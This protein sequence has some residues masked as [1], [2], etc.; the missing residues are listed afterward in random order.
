M[1]AVGTP[2]EWLARRP[3][4]READRRLAVEVS[5]IGVETAEYYP[6]LTLLGNFGGTAQSFGGLNQSIAQRWSYGPSLTWSL[7]DFGRIKQRV[8]AQEARAAGAIAAYQE[9]W[10]KALEET[11]NAMAGYRA[12]NESAAAL[13]YAVS[14][15]RKA[16]ELAQMRFDAGA[17]D[18]LTVLDAERTALDTEDQYVDASTRR[19]TAGG[20]A[21]QG[22]ILAG[23]LGQVAHVPRSCA[24][25]RWRRAGTCGNRPLLA[26][27]A[28]TLRPPP[29]MS[30]SLFAPRVLLLSFS[31]HA[32]RYDL[33]WRLGF[34]PKTKTAIGSLELGKGRDQLRSLDFQFT[35]AYSDISADGKLE[36]KGKRT[37]WTPPEK[38]GTLRW[39]VRIDET[40]ANGAYRSYFPGDWAIFRGDRVFPKAT[41]RSSR[42]PNQR[43]PDSGRSQVLA[44]GHALPRRVRGWPVHRRRPRARLRPPGRLDAGRRH[45]HPSR[46]HLRHRDLAGRAQGRGHAADGHAGIPELHAAGD[47][48]CL[49]HAAAEDPDRLGARPDVARR[50]VGAA[51]AVPASGSPDDQRERHQHAVARTDP[52]RHAYPR[53]ER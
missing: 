1:V 28:P 10:L 52:C 9:T 45:R 27:F 42:A 26:Q 49:W 6:K 18:Y 11:E 21:V 30:R 37:L 48:G 16:S 15:S 5:N 23:S 34:D 53:A 44:S 17:S 38:G 25:T 12:A 41:V 47:E 43:A 40:R 3:D 20:G 13:E 14:E 33:T 4:V 51:F 19:A 31:A 8:L 35:E 39:R 24:S 29:P 46:D 7:L 50:P 2:E 22:G 36:R 32:A